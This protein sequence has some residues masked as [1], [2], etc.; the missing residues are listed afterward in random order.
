M[1]V[2]FERVCVK[3]AGNAVHTYMCILI[4]ELGFPAAASR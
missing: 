2:I 3:K 1:S 4:A